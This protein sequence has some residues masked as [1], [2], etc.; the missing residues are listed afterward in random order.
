MNGGVLPA[1]LL[2][3]AFGLMLGFATRRQSWIGL[4]AMIAS[5]GFASLMPWP[6]T[7]HGTLFAGLW[8]S[9]IVTVALIYLPHGLT[10][11]IVIAVG[12]IDGLLIGALAAI[13][14]QQFAPFA[15]VPL[16]LLF[17][18]VQWL[19][20]RG[21]DIVAKVLSSWMM[22]IAALSFFVSMT[23]TPGYQPDHME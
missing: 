11:A 7:N 19:K 23:P 8:L 10:S 22:A 13:T 1:L 15:A 14:E 20:K 3:A 12:A 5:S 17:I 16:I 2:G 18:P 6:S 21:Y 9:V 4:A